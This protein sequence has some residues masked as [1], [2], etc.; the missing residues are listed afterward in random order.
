MDG[1]YVFAFDQVLES[2][3]EF[4]NS[5]DAYIELDLFVVQSDYQQS[6]AWIPNQDITFETMP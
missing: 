4:I 1:V 2:P 6:W 5:E 3:T